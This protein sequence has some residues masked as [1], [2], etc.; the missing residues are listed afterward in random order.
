LNQPCPGVNDF[1]GQNCA[2]KNTHLKLP[3][4][5]M[6][7]PKAFIDALTYVQNG[8]YV[9]RWNF[10]L[11]VGHKEEELSGLGQPSVVTYDYFTSPPAEY[12]L[13]EPGFRPL[14][15]SYQAS[16]QRALNA[17]AAVC[18]IRFK[19]VTP[20]LIAQVRIGLSDQSGSG[21]E[22]V[23][24]AFTPSYSWTT[25]PNSIILEVTENPKGG[26][27]WINST[28]IYTERDKIPSG[29]LFEVWMHEIGHAVG[30]K[31]PFEE[32][33]MLPYEYNTTRY[34][35]MSYTD[36][37][38]RLSV[39]FTNQ[40]ETISSNFSAIALS[41]P[42]I[43]DIA[44]LQ[45][46]YGANLSTNSGDT[47]YR[48]R[49]SEL[50]RKSLWDGSG[51]DTI[52]CGTMSVRSMISLVPGSYSSIGLIE[53]DAQLM[54]F[55]HVP[56]EWSNFPKLESWKNLYNGQNNLGIAYGCIIENAMGGN[57]AD[58]LIGN[59][60]ANQLFGGM[61]N[62]RISGGAGNDY[63]VGGQGADR[64]TGSVGSDLFVYPSL[65]GS[66]I[67]LGKRDIITDF[68]MQEGDRI[69]ISAIDADPQL[70]GRQTLQY[71]DSNMFTGAPGEV[72][73]S[74]GILQVNLSQDSS[75]DIEIQLDRVIEFGI[76]ALVL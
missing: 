57:S 47:R 18:N 26:D 39:S 9:S 53:S 35:M 4:S 29:R 12:V 69:D 59:F 31:H 55:Y 37:E 63:I 48:F 11:S 23:G 72:R 7:T 49:D 68:N 38:R 43:G 13:S 60:A 40:H 73:F 22:T 41:T 27:I 20:P 70:S 54:E 75:P 16:V 76:S 74:S 50:F 8:N 14:D 36:A 67:G 21:K 25:D 3:K 32:G 44:A 56:K 71:I 45:S 51:N 58:V 28:D 19:R 61:G 5:I 2:I 17:I 1:R 64:L 30:L 65:K 62:D 46:L 10:P 42:M 52:D 33:L 6:I 34:T 66:G 15:G 24:Y